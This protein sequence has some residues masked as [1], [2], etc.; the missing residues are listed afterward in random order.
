MKLGKQRGFSLSGMV[1]GM[2]VLALLALVAAKLSPA[3][4]DYFSIKKI[5]TAMEVNGE[6]KTLGSKDLRM[7]YAKRALIDNVKSITP[8]DLQISKAPDGTAIVSAEYSV[9]TPLVANVS[10]LIDF[11][12]TTEKAE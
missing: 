10:L 9:K 11:T 3:Y 12:V 4:I 5:L 2:V 8:E 7:S 6:L 1:T